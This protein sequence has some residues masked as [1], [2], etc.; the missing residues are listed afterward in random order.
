M[1]DETST[2]ESTP[3]TALE[4]NSEPASRPDYIP[5]KFWDGNAGAANVQALSEAY[6]GLERR[7][8]T[9]SEDLI[10]EME[11]TRLSGRP[12]DSGSYNPPEIEGY[13]WDKKDPLLSFWSEHAFE[14]GMTQEQFSGGVQSYMTALAASAPDPTIEMGKLGEDASARVEALNSWIPKGLSKE[15]GDILSNLANTAEGV[16]ALEEVMAL[17]SKTS[18]SISSTSN[19]EPV[20]TR[21]ELE[22]MI[23]KPSYWDPVKRDM[24]L[25]ATV[26]AGFARLG[27]G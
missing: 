10:A 25:V 13:S 1:T 7:M 6:T 5:E 24:D 4:A 2:E 15:T 14:M 22:A 8:F 18:A 23:S 26:E 11:V 17:S 12:A 20:F 27:R 3:T 19:P 9:K 21:A 16:V